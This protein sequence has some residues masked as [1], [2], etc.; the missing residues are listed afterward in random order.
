MPRRF[1]GA[2]Q[3]QV[4]DVTIPFMGLDSLIASKEIC[5]EQ[6]AVDRQRLLALRR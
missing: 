2:R 3:L 5:R 4:W 1:P 6:A